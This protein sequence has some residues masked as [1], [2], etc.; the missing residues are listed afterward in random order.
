MSGPS[1]TR[2]L[3]G[4]ATHRDIMGRVKFIKGVVISVTRNV[5]V[6]QTDSK[7]VGRQPLIGETYIYWC[8]NC[9]TNVWE[10]ERLRSKGACPFCGGMLS[11]LQAGD[12]MKLHF[13]ANV[14]RDKEGN[15]LDQTSA[16][17]WGEKV[18]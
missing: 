4:K 11:A 8:R 12:K 2:H 3:P 16:G 15:M 5:I 18:I 10:V 13:R 6:V 17:W 9:Q 1:I 7:L 14:Q